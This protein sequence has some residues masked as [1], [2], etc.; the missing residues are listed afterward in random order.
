MVTLTFLPIEITIQIVLI[1]IGISY[2]ITGSRIGYPIRFMFCGALNFKGLREFWYLVKCP[3]CNAWWAGA[4]I[5]FLAGV[6][7][8][9]LIAIAFTCCG[10]VA[11]IQIAL[12]GDGYAANEDF[13]ELFQG[14]PEELIEGELDDGK[15]E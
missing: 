15:T 4:A 5:A 10:V 12:G 14:I 9:Q 8:L 3:A 13:E 2:V 11:V 6:T 7:W 1:A